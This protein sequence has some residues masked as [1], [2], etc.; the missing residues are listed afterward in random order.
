MAFG[1]GESGEEADEESADCEAGIVKPELARYLRL[2]KCSLNTSA[3][4]EASRASLHS[5]LPLNSYVSK[6]VFLLRM[7]CRI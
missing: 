1:V 3:V 5:F 7:I 2:T 4:R 6:T